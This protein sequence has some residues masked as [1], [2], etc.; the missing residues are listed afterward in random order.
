MS[1]HAF[2]FIVVGYVGVEGERYRVVGRNGD[3]DIRI[4]DSFDVMYRYKRPA[5]P[6]DYSTDPVRESEREV[7]IRVTGIEAMNRSLKHLGVG[8]TGALTVE[9]EGIGDIAPGWILGRREPQSVGHDRG[10]NGDVS[11]A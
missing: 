10:V 7:R 1:H 3:E 4:G 5:T 9:G 6:D 11:H 8:M 2:E